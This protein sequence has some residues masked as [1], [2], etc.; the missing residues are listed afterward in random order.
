MDVNNTVKNILY[1]SYDGMTDPLGQSQVLPYLCGLA[2][3][4]YVFTL[5]SCEKKLR[6]ESGKEI[7]KEIADLNN[8]DWHPL[9]YTKK[10]PV[11]S[12][13]FDIRK[14]NKRAMKLH[15]VKKF[16]LVH[17]RGHIP[18][19]SGLLLKRKKKI[20]F[21]FD[22]RGLWA[23]EKVDAGAWNLRNPVFKIIYRY[24]KKKEKAFLLEADHTV[25]LTHNGRSELK[26]WAYLQSFFPALTVI[27]CCTDSRLFDP[28]SIREEDRE[29]L[30]KESGIQPGETIISYLG[31]IGTWYM[32][33]EMLDFFIIFLKAIPN[34]RLL[35]ITYDEHEHIKNVASEKGIDSHSIIIRPA[36]RSEVPLVLSLCSY[37]LFFIRPTYSKI[38]S[39]PT[40]QGEIMGM[41]IPVVCNAGIGDTDMIVNKYKSGVVVP[42]LNTSGY[43]EAVNAL[44]QTRYDSEKIREGCKDFFSL[45]KGVEQYSSIY[46]SIL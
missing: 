37:S 14:V 12:T 11:L 3:K 13:L 28:A 5:I 46:Q 22:M 1:I 24:F 38:S 39:S 7:I 4:G 29:R 20:P 34:S 44:L 40:K 19:L 18:A 10:P 45:E 16:D 15:R 41:G 25:C 27:P 36:K 17:C 32:L 30:R 26:T 21:L 43:E 6:F 2:K 9:P 23:D 31:S 35:F 8:I 33:E 42:N